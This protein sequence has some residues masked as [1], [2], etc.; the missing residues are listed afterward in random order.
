MPLNIGS[1]GEPRAPVDAA[2]TYL[3]VQEIRIHPHASDIGFAAWLRS[4]AKLD[5]ASL[6][7]DQQMQQVFNFIE[8]LVHPDDFDLFMQTARE[9][10]QRFE[11]LG[12]TARAIV[13]AVSRFPTGQRS[14]SPGSPSKKGKKSK[15]GSSSPAGSRD[16][17][18]VHSADNLREMA[19]ARAMR[20]LQ[21]RPDKQIVIARRIEQQEQDERDQSAA[22]G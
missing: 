14:D 8:D 13:G 11:D 4:A 10:N 2:F 15:G 16:A 1:I 5:M 18:T 7:E 17:G 20:L 12:M 6:S 21:G 19:P 3:G 22:A 9:H